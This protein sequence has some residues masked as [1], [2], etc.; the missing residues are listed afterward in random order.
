MIDPLKHFLIAMFCEANDVD[1]IFSSDSI[2]KYGY[3]YALKKYASAITSNI[4]QRT[5]FINDDKISLMGSMFCDKWSTDLDEVNF[6]GSGSSHN[7]FYALCHYTS[8]CLRVVDGKPI[9]K[10]EQLFKWNELTGKLGQDMLLCSFMAYKNRYDN[11]LNYGHKIPLICGVDNKDLNLIY[12]KGLVELHQHLKASCDIFSLS[13]VCLM[14]KVTGRLS[15]FKDLD[16]EN[17]ELLFKSFYKAAKLRFYIFNYRSALSPNTI[18]PPNSEQSPV[19]ATLLLPGVLP[20]S[21]LIV[22]VPPPVNLLGN[23]QLLPWEYA[24]FIVKPL[25]PISSFTSWFPPLY[26]VL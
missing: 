25:T 9:V 18:D 3:D 1:K 6:R 8:R 5:H 4:Q 19:K 7:L 14:N 13:W 22:M 15:N 11:R 24:P 10:F 26:A 21:V 16:K 17:Y 12:Q 20:F 2:V 23:T